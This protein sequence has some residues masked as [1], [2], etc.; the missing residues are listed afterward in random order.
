MALPDI[1]AEPL[2]AVVETLHRHST[3]AAVCTDLP[4]LPFAEVISKCYH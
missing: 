1:L 2:T 3:V 4:D